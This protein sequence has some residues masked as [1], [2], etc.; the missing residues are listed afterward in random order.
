HVLLAGPGFGSH[1]V[2]WTRRRGPY[3]REEAQRSARH[4]TRAH[5]AG[6][7]AHDGA[8]GHEHLRER[9]GRR[10][11]S[12]R[13]LWRHHREVALAHRA[14]PRVAG[15]PGAHTAPAA[16]LASVPRYLHVHD[17][18]Q[19]SRAHP[20]AAAGDCGTA[21][22]VV[23][24]RV[25]APTPAASG[26]NMPMLGHLRRALH[27]SPSSHGGVQL[28]RYGIVVVCGYVLAIVLYS[29]E[30]AIGIEPYLALGIAFVL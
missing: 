29:G 28:I 24:G 30:L 20:A 4:P 26:M 14:R 8:D 10:R 7:P 3:A 5:H 27:R 16:R 19:G 13:R 12:P 9:V 15:E 1:S 21:R 25:A 11:L 22:M 17:Q 2:S 18:L 23:R 6:G